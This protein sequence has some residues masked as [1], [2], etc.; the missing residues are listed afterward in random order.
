[1]L[2]PFTRALLE[3]YDP[4]R[5]VLPW[6]NTR[7]PYRI[8]LS[9]IML[10]QTRVEQGIP[11][12]HRFIVAFPTVSDLAL[13]PSARVMKLWEGL[14]Y[15]SRAR[16]LHSAAQQVVHEFGGKFP[17]SYEDIR[18]LKGVGDYTAAAIASFAFDQ[19]YAVLD[20][21]VFRVL[22]RYFGES[23]PVDTSAGKKYYSRLARS[24]LPEDDAARYNQAIMDFGALV[25]TP[26]QPKCSHCP[27]SATCKAL[28]TSIPWTT[29]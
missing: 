7:D 17:E 3:W 26:R 29:L 4:K 24:L 10:Q 5:R 15:Y 21:N 22:S 27:L 9:E 1:M 23:V 25:C 13:A 6:K 28:N 19:P 12:Y 20:G 14:G 16:N 2:Q 11:Y 18:S 8:W